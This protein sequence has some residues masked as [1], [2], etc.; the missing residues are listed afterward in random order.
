MQCKAV[1]TS[2][3]RSFAEIVFI[4]PQTPQ[5][6]QQIRT[7]A[8]TDANLQSTYVLASDIS[9]Y[10]AVSKLMGGKISKS[11]GHF[12]VLYFIR[13]W[14]RLLQEL[15]CAKCKAPTT[16]YGSI[17]MGI[18][19]CDFG[20]LRKQCH[21]LQIRESICAYVHS[22]KGLLESHDKRCWLGDNSCD[23]QPRDVWRRGFP[24]WPRVP[25]SEGS[26]F[27]KAIDCVY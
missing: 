18:S 8:K 12:P 16:A 13:P 11:P 10:L 15:H 20:K 4:S 24:Q 17:L 19:V 27:M 23:Q 9:Q 22:A 21:H 2:N 14:M 6:N 1:Q 25:R 26:G 3:F 5:N 7:L